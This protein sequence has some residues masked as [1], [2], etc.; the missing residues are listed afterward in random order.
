MEPL[1]IRVFESFILVKLQKMMKVVDATSF[2][3][4]Y[5]L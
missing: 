3:F 5:L 2:T 4:L 1:T